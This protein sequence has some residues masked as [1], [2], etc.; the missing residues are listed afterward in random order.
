MTS[1]ICPSCKYLLTPSDVFCPECGTKYIKQDVSITDQAYIEQPQEV[2]SAYRATLT[3]EPQ[4]QNI[5][6]EQY[7]YKA[8]TFDSYMMEV[9][10]ERR[11][12]FAFDMSMSNS[13]A[14]TASYLNNK[15]T[16]LVNDM[17]NY[18]GKQGWEYWDYIEVPVERIKEMAEL[19]GN[20]KSALSFMT[21]GIK[22]GLKDKLSGTENIMP[23]VF[24]HYI[25]RK[26]TL[27]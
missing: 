3:T 22:A 20:N 16:G 27:N 13:F 10:G 12:D 8:V 15:I 26:V 2:A 18:Y 14:A 7:L 6:G 24:T 1:K 23:T 11:K 25:F 21:A 9:L 19:S 5:G 17:F 4:G